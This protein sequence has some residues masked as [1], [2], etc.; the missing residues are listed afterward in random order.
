MPEVRRGIVLR[1]IAGRSLLRVHSREGP[2]EDTF[3]TVTSPS[4]TTRRAGCPPLSTIADGFLMNSVDNDNL[5][6][7]ALF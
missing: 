7:L 4:A 3:S 1:R 2:H 5:D 6:S